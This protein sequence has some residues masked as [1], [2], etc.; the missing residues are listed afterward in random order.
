M[1]QDEE[2]IL[3]RHVKIRRNRERIAT[4]L[5]VTGFSL[6]GSASILLFLSWHLYNTHNWTPV[7]VPLSL[8]ATQITR[9]EFV[10]DM[11]TTYFVQIDLKRAENSEVTGEPSIAWT[12]THENRSVGEEYSGQYWGETI[13]YEIGTF[14]GKSGQK[15]SLEAHVKHDSPLLRVLDPHLQIAVTPID[16][17]RY[18]VFCAMMDW[19][20]MFIFLIAIFCL[21][22]S[23]RRTTT[24]YCNA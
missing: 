21:V 15:Y 5:L 20:S 8:S 1:R 23:R 2:Q 19:L 18:M 13:G 12:V 22:L 24:R 11:D 9:A 10:A 17:E 16:N 14:R 4:A 6:L 7:H 3:S